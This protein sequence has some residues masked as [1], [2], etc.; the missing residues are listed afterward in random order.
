MHNL[1]Q[2]MTPDISVLGKPTLYGSHYHPDQ[3]FPIPRQPKRE[4]IG[5]TDVIPFFGVDI[6]NHYEVSWLN[7]K[8]KPMVALAKIIYGCESKNIIES[9]SMK[10]Y[11]NSLNNTCFENVEAVQAVVKRDLL[12]RLGTAQMIVRVTPIHR[13]VEEKPVLS[14]PGTCLDTLDI[15]CSVYSVE[16]AFLT[17]DQ[18]TVEETLYSDLLKSNC[19]VTN[20]PD[21]C[22]VQISYKGRKINHAGLLRYIV[23]FRNSNE[24]HE[25]CIEKI[26]M[27]IMQRCQ[28]KALT[29]YGRST[30]RGGID[31]NSYRS[32][33]MIEVSSI[34]NTRLCRQ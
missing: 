24:F 1:K 15:D 13:L 28:P 3:L 30:R 17:V 26:F 31:I 18:D 12:D 25:Q 4:E 14:L 21:W 2:T 20:Q 6:W 8:G 33:Q 23:S 9:K 16:S 27:H 34:P 7:E 11:F 22:S 10:L 19:L 5:V 29:V 32:T